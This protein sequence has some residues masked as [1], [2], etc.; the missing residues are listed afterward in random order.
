MIH[1]PV[2]F[3]AWR[4]DE[5]NQFFFFIF[6]TYGRLQFVQLLQKQVSGRISTGI[7]LTPFVSYSVDTTDL[8]ISDNIL[9]K[10]SPYIYILGKML[11]VRFR[12][13]DKWN[14]TLPCHY[15]SAPLI[16]YF[17][18]YI[19]NVCIF[20]VIMSIF[21]DICIFKMFVYTLTFSINMVR[22]MRLMRF[23][24][25]T[26]I[27]KVNYYGVNASLSFGYALINV[28]SLVHTHTNI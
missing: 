11:S 14:S 13:I 20:W 26:Y 16:Q 24:R 4:S 18:V 1:C 8:K 9:A 22:Y 19:H 27:H 25:E 12:H 6:V 3:D 5:I 28:S 7:L 21:W 2:H 23:W 10:I 15:R 17:F